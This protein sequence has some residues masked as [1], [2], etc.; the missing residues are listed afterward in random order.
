MS[1]DY[2]HRLTHLSVSKIDSARHMLG[3]RF[4]YCVQVR[5]LTIAESGDAGDSTCGNELGENNRI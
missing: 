4:L 5:L 3:K 2:V 1:G